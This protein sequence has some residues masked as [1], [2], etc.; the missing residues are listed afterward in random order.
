MR[1]ACASERKKREE[2][3][4]EKRDE[5]F[6]AQSGFHR[7]LRGSCTRVGGGSSFSELLPLPFLSQDP[8]LQERWGAALKTLSLHPRI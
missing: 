3:E 1:C 7:T 6:I 8:P 4:R 2:R 5:F